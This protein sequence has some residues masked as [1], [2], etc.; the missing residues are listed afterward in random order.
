MNGYKNLGNWLQEEPT[1][2]INKK[3]N[4][5][6]RDYDED[7]LGNI[8]WVILDDKGMMMSCEWRLNL[9]E[10]LKEADDMCV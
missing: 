1:Y 8:M 2:W 6:V 9:L 10:C 4:Y 7:S 5:V 3:T